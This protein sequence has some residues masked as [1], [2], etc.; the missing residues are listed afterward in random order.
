MTDTTTITPML[1]TCSDPLEERLQLVE[2]LLAAQ[3]DSDRSPLEAALG[4]LIAAGG[5]R[6]RP[7]MALLS[8]CILGAEPGKLLCLAAAVE[9]LHTATLVHDD[10][11]D[12]ARLRRGVAT[13]NASGP[14]AASVLAGDFAFTRSARLV[15]A[16]GCLPA[17]DMFTQ[18]MEMIVSGEI[19]HLETPPTRETYLRWIEAKTAALFELAAGAPALLSTT[20][21]EMAT[22]ARR[23]GNRI[24]MAFQIMDDVLDFTGQASQLGKPAGNDLSQGTL[25]LPALLYFEAHPDDPD[26]Q[27]L[28]RGER[29][30]EA[31]VERLL[32]RIRASEAIEQAM[33][34]ARQ[35]VREGLEH[36]A[37]MPEVRERSALSELAWSVVERDH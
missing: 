17:I 36:L 16:T 14:A 27:A 8:G 4:G 31:H 30:D 28:A 11:V 37:V 22:A 33:Q 15:L 26:L 9:M 29:P 32:V 10:L 2:A 35:F 12:G 18:C 24:G 34:A 21:A 20:G 3:V 25:T 19:R 6:L 7:R 13:L 1:L 5:K 23:F